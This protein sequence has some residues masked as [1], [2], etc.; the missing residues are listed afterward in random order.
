MAHATQ[1]EYGD[2]GLCLKLFV[3]YVLKK[4][5]CM[6]FKW[7]TVYELLGEYGHDVVKI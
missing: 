5:K 7:D 4:R 6:C 2:E 1:Q 3:N